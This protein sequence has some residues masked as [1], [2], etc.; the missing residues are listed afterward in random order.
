MTVVTEVLALTSWTPDSDKVWVP[1]AGPSGPIA[2][3]MYCI[4][5]VGLYHSLTACGDRWT[6]S[7]E[8]YGDGRLGVAAPALAVDTEVSYVESVV[9][10]HLPTCFGSEDLGY[11]LWIA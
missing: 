10:D 5:D 11:D 7:L 3:R 9:K 8:Y 2:E 1:R 4:G 6:Y